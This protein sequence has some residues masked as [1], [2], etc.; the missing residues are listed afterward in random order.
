MCLKYM[1]SL[2]ADKWHYFVESPQI[3][4]PQLLRPS[5]K[6]WAATRPRKYFRCLLPPWRQRDHSVHMAG[7]CQYFQKLKSAIF[8]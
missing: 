4:H 6:V 8:C 3:S 1:E 7:S 2:S 5:A